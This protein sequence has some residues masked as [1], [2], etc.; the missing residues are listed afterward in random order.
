M[1]YSGASWLI[2]K[3]REKEERPQELYQFL[4]LQRGQTVCDFGCGNGYHAIQMAKLVGP[5]GKVYAVDIQEEMLAL[6]EQRASTRGLKNIEL[7]LAK[8]SDSGLPESQL[9][10]VLMVDVYHELSDPPTVLAEIKRALSPKGTLVL[11]EFREEDPNVPIRPLHKMSKRQIQREMVAEGFRLTAQYDQL[12]WQ[13]VMVY[14][15]G[16]QSSPAVK[17]EAW[18]PPSGSGGETD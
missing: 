12:P 6:L 13:H 16:Q 17:L 15:T 10:M 8:P 3:S 14:S 7:V 5:R 11:V 18:A 4:K 2:R 1:S 9:D